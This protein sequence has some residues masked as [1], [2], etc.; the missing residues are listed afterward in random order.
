MRFVLQSLYSVA[1]ETPLGR[2]IFRKTAPTMIRNL[3]LR[4][5]ILLSLSIFATLQAGSFTAGNLAV[6]QTDASAI[7]TTASIIELV[8]STANQTPTNSIAILGTG[9]TA[10]RFSGSGTST[11]YLATSDDRSLLSF[12]GANSTD[13]TT[14]VNALNPRGVAT[15]SPS[16]SIAIATN[17]TGSGTNQTRGATSVNNTNWF[18]G[19]A[20]GLY[21]NGTSAPSPAGNLR[22]MKS[23]GGTVYGGSSTL[24]QVVTSNALTGGTLTGLPGL[25]STANVNFQDFYLIS[26]GDNGSTYDVLYIVS[27]TATAAGTINKYSLVTGTWTANGSYTTNFGGFGLAAADNGNGALLYVS[28]GNGATTANKVIK[29][30]D[31]AGYNA[32]I[33][34][35]TASNVTLYTA[36]TG[37]SVKGVAFTP[38]TNPVPDLAVTVTAPANG[39]VGTNFDYTITAT[40]N[41]SVSA[42]GVSVQ[43][44]IP[45]GLNYVSTSGSGFAA[46][47]ASGV[48]TFTGG[49]LAGSASAVL[50]VTVTP[51]S[52]ATYSA[53]IGAAIIDPGNTIVES[54]ETNNNSP[55]AASTVVVLPNSPPIFTAQ[56]TATQPVNYGATTTL[57][58]TVTGN[59]TPTLQWYQ[60]LSGDTSTPVSGAT[61]ASFTTP[62]VTANINYWARATNSVAST[63][64]NTAAI[65]V[66]LSTNANLSALVPNSGSLSPTF[67]SGTTSYKV[68]AL[69]TTT[70]ITFTPT[71]SNANSTLQI[72]INSGAYSPITSGTA[73]SALAL[74][75]GANLVEILI[76]AQDGST[77]RFYSI[78][79]TRYAPLLAT[80]SIA[81]VGYNADGNDDIAFVALT[82]IPENSAIYFTDNEWNGQAIGSGGAFNDFNESEWLWT[83]P[84]GGIT[85]G[86]VVTINSISTG[87][88]TTTVGTVAFTDSA[89]RGLSTSSDAVYAFQGLSHLPQVFLTEISSDTGSSIANTGLTLGSTAI[90]LAAS[91]DGAV[92]TGSR[93]NQS[94]FAAYL[95]I[96]NN[97]ANWNDVGDGDGT[98]L[99][100]F[101]PTAFTLASALSPINTWRLAKFG[102]T[103]TDGNLASNA[104]YDNDSIQNL[105]EYGLGTE[106]TIG[107]GT[108]G[109][110]ALPQL[111]LSDANALL[112][113]RL[114]LSFALANPNPSDL[115]YIVQASDDL[116][117][118]SDVASKTGTAAWTWLAG[119]TSRIVTSGT[120]TITVKIGDSVPADAAHPRRLMRLKVTNP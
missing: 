29:L 41:G 108:N 45:S 96:V 72:R 4:S 118:W 78:N 28:T 70:S 62:A 31:T 79:V 18:I 86:T 33:A 25:S 53:P 101:S 36:P 100:P 2:T 67:A 32:T 81:F 44:T 51:T 75:E 116:G 43:F 98:T 119:G 90:A 66:V 42:T 23:F 95:P 13:T 60:G 30:A 114:A 94:T 76:T 58:I 61:S 102:S 73:S 97:I 120:G 99:L 10:M 48:V 84:T 93:S 21:T 1:D 113:D 54:N 35:T 8:P 74:N 103:S 111:I 69:N 39:T 40:N 107:S 19:D 55:V 87:T 89:S 57:T 17:Y 59:P 22:G 104:D 117:I 11:G 14:N 6:L 52:A 50:T 71:S 109:P 47:Q 91:S 82:N 26:S 34:I 46:A 115:T 112:T 83:P 77:T 27:A 38:V 65:T 24:T 68:A 85:A 15:L 56:P 105:V 16:G 37:K 64:S 63:D 9:A 80:G 5:G 92:Y 110:S 106:P 12:T 49:T 7:N 20:G 3:L 88:T